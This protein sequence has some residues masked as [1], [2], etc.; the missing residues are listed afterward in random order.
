LGPLGGKTE[1]REGID[2][3]LERRALQISAKLYQKKTILFVKQVLE[4]L[5][6]YEQENSTPKKR[7]DDDARALD[8]RGY[9]ELFW[10]NGR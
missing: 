10:V 2:K 3:A 5:N 7:L 4:A 6:G 8:Q 1:L 9:T